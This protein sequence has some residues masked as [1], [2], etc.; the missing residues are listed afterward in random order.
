MSKTGELIVVA[1]PMF[2]AKTSHLIDRARQYPDTSLILKPSMDDRY[3]GGELVHSHDG[4]SHRARLFDAKF[5][6]E[7]LKIIEEYPNLAVVL[8][9]EVQFCAQEILGV[10]EKLLAKGLTVIAAGL[11][12]DYQK[13]GFGPMPQLMEKA[14]EVVLLTARCDNE[15]CDQPATFTYAKHPLDQIENVG[16]DEIFGVACAICY[17]A[18]RGDLKS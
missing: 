10:I 11:D 3:G 9:D 8:I 2:A 1:G 5:P 12:L 14:D 4:E 16:A 18:L 17:D 13:Q 6:A 7:I 15:D